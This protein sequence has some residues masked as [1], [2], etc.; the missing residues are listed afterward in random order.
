MSELLIGLD[1]VEGS[2]AVVMRCSGEVDAHTCARLE[3]AMK[4]ILDG[5][6]TRVIVDLTGVPYMA[7]RGLGVL[8]SARKL[9][10]DSGGGLVLLNPNEAVTS[11]IEVL[12]FDSVFDIVATEKDAIDLIAR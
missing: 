7:S 6:L 10:E 5:G 2:S 3:S 8:I 12:G 9:I 1:P 11:A 4:E